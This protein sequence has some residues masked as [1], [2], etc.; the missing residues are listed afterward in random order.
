MNTPRRDPD[1]REKAI[2][3]PDE[4]RAKQNVNAP[5]LLRRK[6]GALK[7]KRITKNDC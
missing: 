6:E 4:Q 5:M 7:K 1:E 3:L 2:P